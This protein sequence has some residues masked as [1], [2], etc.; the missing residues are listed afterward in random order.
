MSDQKLHAAPA[1]GGAAPLEGADI[2]VRVDKE[3]MTDP[4]PPVRPLDAPPGFETETT[5]T[6]RSRPKMSLRIPDD[7]VARPSERPPPPLAPTNGADEPPISTPRPAISPT[8]II[9]INPPSTP[10]AVELAAVPA[11]AAVAAAAD[12]AIHEA[13]T[14]VDMSELAAPDSTDSADRLTPEPQTRPSPKIEV[15]HASSSEL[16]SDHSSPAIVAGAPAGA[17]LLED[18]DPGA[19]TQESEAAK[20]IPE[21]DDSDGV[22]VDVDSDS[23]PPPTSDEAELLADDLMSIESLPL[24]LPPPPKVPSV[25]P[26]PAAQP[27]GQPGIDGSGASKERPLVAKASE[28]LPPPAPSSALAQSSPAHSGP[29]ADPNKKRVRHWWEDLFNDD[30]VRTMAKITDAQIAREAKF[31]EESL[32]VATGAAL[33]DLGCGTGLHAIELTKRGY[34]VV[35]FDLSLAM[36]ARAADEAQ[37]RNTKI[38]FV[39]GDMREMGFDALFDGVYS[40]NTS[41]GYFDEEKNAEVLRRVHRA[42]K[43]GGQ[44]LLEV[45]NRD[46]IIKQSPSLAWFEGDGCICMDEMQLD[47]ITS[48]MRVKRTMMMDDG[49]SREIE[50]SMRAY[51]LHELGKLLHEQGFRVAEVSGRVATPGVFFGN[52]APRI[53]VLAEKR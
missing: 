52:E 23:S 19:R 33:L 39:Q 50:Y 53:I 4:T 2:D 1:N 43:K 18:S 28:A 16:T 9:A 25:P 7:E 36:L 48:R 22:D 41:F 3:E 14:R 35:G 51:S 38:N 20:A 45:V 40:W 6:K 24:A 10:D 46:Y 30:F 27:V 8:R 26:I 11:D 31:I 17:R 21:A 15:E 42:L 13:P 49:R 12:D 5:K 32:G 37:E 34:Q 44:L 29:L 47:F